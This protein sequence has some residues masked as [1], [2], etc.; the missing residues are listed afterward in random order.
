ME[1]KKITHKV[2]PMRLPADFSAET[3]QTEREWHDIFKV[4]KRKNIQQRT[5]YPARLSFIFDREIKSY[6]GKSSKNSAAEFQLWLS[7]LRIL[8]VSMS[9]QVRSLALLSGIATSCRVG[10]KC[11]LDPASLWPW[12]RLAAVALIRPLALMLK[13]QLQKEK[14]NPAPINQLYNKC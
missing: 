14:K 4:M 3:L 11:G 2:I 1:K 7:R 12:H 6:I 8:P 9:M 10:S 13:V 5:L